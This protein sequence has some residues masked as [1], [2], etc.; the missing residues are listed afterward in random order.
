MRGL[1]MNWLN[2]LAG[3][4]SGPREAE[5][6]IPGAGIATGTLPGAVEPPISA[7]VCLS[8]IG[9]VSQVASGNSGTKM[10]LGHRMGRAAL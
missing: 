3:S 7:P 1:M 2:A 6:E 9:S 4:V 10:A 8:E 5:I